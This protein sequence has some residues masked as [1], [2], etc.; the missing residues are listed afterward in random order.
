MVLQLLANAGRKENKIGDSILE[1]RWQLLFANDTI[2]QLKNYGN[3][4]SGSCQNKYV[5]INLLLPLPTPIEVHGSSESNQ[6]HFES[7]RFT[8]MV[9]MKYSAMHLC[10]FFFCVS[11][12]LIPSLIRGTLC[13]GEGGRL[14]LLE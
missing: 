3:E 2:F 10:T 4:N 6:M 1:R 13:P 8:A 9:G 12:H 14:G 5:S 11:E 7:Q